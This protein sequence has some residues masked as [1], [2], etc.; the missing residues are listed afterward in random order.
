MVGILI[1]LAIVYLIIGV[2]VYNNIK[3]SGGYA[4]NPEG[5][6]LIIVLLWIFVLKRYGKR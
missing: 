2:C 5:K 4:I 6:F 1:F 3:S